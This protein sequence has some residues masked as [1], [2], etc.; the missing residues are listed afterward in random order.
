MI[1]IEPWERSGLEHPEGKMLVLQ[2]VVEPRRSRLA[3][4]EV[5][6]LPDSRWTLVAIS[7]REKA[8]ADT[9]VS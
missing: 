4:K 6:Y 7:L 3:V 8:H 5:P 9:V 2:E 1:S